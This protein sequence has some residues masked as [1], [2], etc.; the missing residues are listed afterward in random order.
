MGWD[1]DCRKGHGLKKINLHQICGEFCTERKTPGLP[2]L[3]DQIEESIKRQEK[4]TVDYSQVKILSASFLDELVGPWSQSG[5][6]LKVFSEFVTFS[7][8]LN[9]IQQRILERRL[10]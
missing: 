3:R 1:T 6:S 4:V 7:P 2:E 10:R 9:A 8:Q 5:M